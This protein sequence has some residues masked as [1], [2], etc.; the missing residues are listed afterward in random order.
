VGQGDTQEEFQGQELLICSAANHSKGLP[1]CSNQSSQSMRPV[2]HDLWMQVCFVIGSP[3]SHA[4]KLAFIAQ[5]CRSLQTITQGLGEPVQIHMNAQ[6]IGEAILDPTKH[7]G[8]AHAT[9]GRLGISSPPA[10]G[11]GWELFNPSLTHQRGKLIRTPAR[12]LSAKMT[13]ICS[14]TALS[15]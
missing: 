3:C 1:K 15:R 5:V 8:R 2:L 9:E 10:S 13:T 4:R 14:L 7:A 12:I 11:H 6:R